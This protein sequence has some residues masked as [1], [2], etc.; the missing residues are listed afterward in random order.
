MDIR[1]GQK[2]KTQSGIDNE[3][4][5][6]GRLKKTEGDRNR[7]PREAM[8]MRIDTKEDEGQTDRRRP[9]QKRRL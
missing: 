4:R 5:H 1:K 2:R 3:I 7:R 6:N 8:R 9:G